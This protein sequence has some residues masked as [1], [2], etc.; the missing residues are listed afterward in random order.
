MGPQEA[1]HLFSSSALLGINCQQILEI[2]KLELLEI[3]YHMD[4]SIPRSIFIVHIIWKKVTVSCNKPSTWTHQAIV[5]SALQI[6]LL[7][8][9]RGFGCISCHSTRPNRFNRFNLKNVFWHRP[10]PSKT[11]MVFPAFGVSLPQRLLRFLF[12]L[13]SRTW[14]LTWTSPQFSS[15]ELDVAFFCN[16][17]CRFRSWEGCRW[18]RWL[19]LKGHWNHI[20]LLCMLKWWCDQKRFTL[21]KYQNTYKFAEQD[22]SNS[23]LTWNQ[24]DDND[25]PMLRYEQDGHVAISKYSGHLLGVS[26]MQ[27]MDKKQKFFWLRLGVRHR[28]MR[29]RAASVQKRLSQCSSQL[30]ALFTKR[31]RLMTKEPL[32]QLCL[33]VLKQIRKNS[34]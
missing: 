26:S 2:R 21:H 28:Y 4:I 29:N 12:L 13:A 25:D 17:Q 34:R 19:R 33:V 9:W 22:I 11:K 6:R 14:T 8:S 24:H 18:L 16:F 15:I 20:S 1:P 30:A 32:S 27:Q 23:L 7:A 31:S 10:E 3:L 5:A